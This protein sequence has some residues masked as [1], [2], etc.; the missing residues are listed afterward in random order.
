MSRAPDSF[1]V[2]PFADRSSYWVSFGFAGGSPDDAAPCGLA[3]RIL[4]SFC[5][6]KALELQS[7][8]NNSHA[9]YPFCST[10]VSVATSVFELTGLSN[11]HRHMNVL[12]AP[13]DPHLLQYL[14]K[15]EFAHSVQRAVFEL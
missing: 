3:A 13:A 4:A 1:A 14:S 6:E 5:E 9:G 7:I 15:A 11:M 8:M 12:D 10:F 2:P